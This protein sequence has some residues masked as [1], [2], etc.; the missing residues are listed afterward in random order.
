MMKL[1]VIVPCYNVSKYVK[2]C[3]ESIIA[4][5]LKDYEIIMV[6]DGSTDH[7]L[8]ILKSLSKKYKEIKIVDKENGGLS[9][10]RNAGIRVSEGEYLAFVDSDDTVDE[11]MFSKMLEKA[12]GG[13]FD[14]VTCGVKMIYTDK[15][16]NVGPS[17]ECDLINKEEIKRQMYDFYP[18]ACNKIF[19]KSCFKKLGFKDG[20]A[21]EDVE[22]IYRLLPNIQSVGVVNGYYYN[23]FQREGSITYS[24]NKNLYDLVSNMDSVLEYYKDNHLLEE[25]HEE[26]EYTYVRYLYA[27]FV[28][29]LAKMNDKKEYNK[30]VQYV[31]D[32][33]NCHF[34]NYKKN[35]YISLSK[36]GKYLKYFNK[37]VANVV[38]IVD[39]K[40]KN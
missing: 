36:K 23:Y 10:A 29:R 24:Y 28:R 30:G 25:Y 14:I 19:K 38:Y 9:S 8:D 11:E 18:A 21:Y 1:S 35:Y 13:D 37:F 5:K 26:I 22:F 16:I 12:S 15:T 2:S 6:N 3:V 17:F 34:P 33:V 27:T 4:N 39:R 31:I 7:T 20:V 32:K 40:K